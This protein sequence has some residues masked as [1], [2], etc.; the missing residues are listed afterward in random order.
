MAITLKISVR[1]TLKEISCEL[2]RPLNI[3]SD[4]EKGGILFLQV[5][6]MFEMKNKNENKRKHRVPL[7]FHKQEEKILF[8]NLT[9]KLA[10]RKSFLVKV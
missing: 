1:F 9:I 3:I 2:S 5:T 4:S 6:V 8:N 7:F 10:E